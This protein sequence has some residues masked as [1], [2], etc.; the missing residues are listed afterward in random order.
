MPGSSGGLHGAC[1]SLR[2]STSLNVPLHSVGC[3]RRPLAPSVVRTVARR[4]RAYSG[5]R[6]RVVPVDLTC[7][8]RL[9]SGWCTCTA[10]LR[11]QQSGPHSCSRVTPS[12]EHAAEARSAC[13]EV[14]PVAPCHAQIREPHVLQDAAAPLNGLRRPTLSSAHTRRT[15]FSPVPR[16]SF[17]IWRSPTSRRR[18]DVPMALRRSRPVRERAAEDR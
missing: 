8:R 14:D 18:V 16:A 15:R 10:S 4:G 12:S 13:A 11:A 7:H 9:R 5:H 3:R 2:A 17:S 6:G 1:R